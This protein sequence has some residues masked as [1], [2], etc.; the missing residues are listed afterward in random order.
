MD[1]EF[2]HF[3]LLD[4]ILYYGRPTARMMKNQEKKDRL[5]IPELFKQMVLDENHNSIFSGHL[6]TKKT[7]QQVSRKVLLE[8]DVSFS[9]R[10]D[11]HVC[12]LCHE[13]RQA[14]IRIRGDMR[15]IT[16]S[17]PLEIVGADIL[18]PLPMTNQ[19]NR[20]ILVFTDH[21]TKWVEA[22]AIPK[23]SAEIV[24]KCFVEGFVCRHGDSRE[25]ID[26]QRKSI[27]RR[28]DDIIHQKLGTDPLKNSRISS[29]DKWNHGKVQ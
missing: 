21:F 5:V 11:Q 15:S 8:R 2:E 26:R 13:E 28:N 7:Y 29:G 24:A 10:M 3:K 16:V 22:I 4:G 12:G 9:T 18:E 27:H 25:V 14:R 23:Q 6:G 20:Y 1:Q 17:R 19:G